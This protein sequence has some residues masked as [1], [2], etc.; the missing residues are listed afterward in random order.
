MTKPHHTAEHWAQRPRNLEGF[1]VTKVEDGG[2]HLTITG[3]HGWT[4]GRSKSDLGRDISIGDD[5]WIET[6]SSRKLPDY[7]TA[8]AGYF[9]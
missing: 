1:V 6:V 5:L 4:F 3:D 2:D 9:G 7:A 8:T